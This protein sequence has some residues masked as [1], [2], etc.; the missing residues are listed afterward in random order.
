MNIMQKKIALAFVWLMVLIAFIDESMV[1]IAAACAALILTPTILKKK[2]PQRQ[3]I[4]IRQKD[5]QR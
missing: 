5:N 4:G 1:G 3:K 2:E